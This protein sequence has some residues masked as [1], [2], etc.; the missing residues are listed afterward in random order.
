MHILGLNVMVSYQIL[1]HFCDGMFPWVNVANPGRALIAL[2][3][4]LWIF[5][6]LICFTLYVL[7]VFAFT[8]IDPAY[9]CFILVFWEASE[10]N[11]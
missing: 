7:Y 3:G 2:L 1:W 4:K 9:F 8:C 6:I 11:N 10:M 5:Q